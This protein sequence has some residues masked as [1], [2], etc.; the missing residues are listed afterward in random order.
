M[1]F[2]SGISR[3]LKRNRRAPLDK[4]GSGGLMKAAN[5]VY[6][7]EMYLR[8]YLTEDKEELLGK[9]DWDLAWK[10]AIDNLEQGRKLLGSLSK[11]HE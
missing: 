2:Y 10:I 7:A 9:R 11:R 5:A 4:W 3:K 6:D 1:K 8:R